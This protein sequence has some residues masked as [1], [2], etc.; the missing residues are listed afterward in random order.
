MISCFLDIKLEC[1]WR[2]NVRVKLVATESFSH[3]AEFLMLEPDTQTVDWS[4][5][6]LWSFFLLQW[7]LELCFVLLVSLSDSHCHSLVFHQIMIVAFL[8]SW[9]LLVVGHCFIIPPPGRLLSS[10][11]LG[12]KNV[13]LLCEV[14][15][16]S[17]RPQ[18]EAGI[19]ASFSC[20]L[21]LHL[22]RLCLNPSTIGA[23]KHR[24]VL[25]FPKHYWANESGS[26]NVLN[27]F[28]AEKPE[29]AMIMWGQKR[30]TTCSIGWKILESMW[31]RTF[32]N[33]TF[34]STHIALG[35]RL[36]T[37]SPTI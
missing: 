20:M 29:M 33:R 6:L 27:G 25:H 31:V 22:M 13:P 5:C 4:S 36:G 16:G 19:C 1:W 24:V 30:I 7:K 15:F 26:K 23:W 8:A 18:Q 11:G 32:L 14:V 2:R 12:K 3:A 17:K 10:G 9:P 35:K 34:C 21:N 37:T 28:V